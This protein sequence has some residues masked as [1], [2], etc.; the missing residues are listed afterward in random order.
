[1]HET[2]RHLKIKLSV[3]RGTVR[4]CNVTSWFWVWGEGDFERKEMFFKILI[5]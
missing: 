3:E 1:M 2:Q 5:K 4:I